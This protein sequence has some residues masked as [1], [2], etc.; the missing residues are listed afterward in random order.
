MAR[1]ERKRLPDLLLVVYLAEKT[2]IDL[3]NAFQQDG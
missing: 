3:G 2:S 1:V